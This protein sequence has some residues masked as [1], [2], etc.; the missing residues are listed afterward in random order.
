M[1]GARSNYYLRAAMGGRIGLISLLFLPFV[2]FTEVTAYDPSPIYWDYGLTALGTHGQEFNLF[3]FPSGLAIIQILMFLLAVAL[4]YP[5]SRCWKWHQDPG[6]ETAAEV[7]TI[8]RVTI[9]IGELAVLL[10]AV[11][12]VFPGRGSDDLADGELGMDRRLVARLR[13]LRDGPHGGG[14]GRCPGPEGEQD[15]VGHSGSTADRATAAA[16][17]KWWVAEMAAAGLRGLGVSGKDAQRRRIRRCVEAEDT[18]GG[19]EGRRDAVTI[20][21]THR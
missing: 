7:R 11:A 20:S 1:S 16:F 5:I 8:S 10:V 14:H 19:V 4:I 17:L 15:S 12:V 9:G 18:A 2:G 13:R 6:S 3:G 21:V